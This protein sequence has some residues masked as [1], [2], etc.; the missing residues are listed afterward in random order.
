MSYVICDDMAVP[1]AAGDP[2]FGEP[3]SSYISVCDEIVQHTS[4]AGVHFLA[5]NKQ[6][7]K[8]LHNSIAEVKVWI[9]GFV[10]AKDG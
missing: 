5:D 3:G 10:K 7:F 2:M 4:H 6:V 1:A 8:I 9:K